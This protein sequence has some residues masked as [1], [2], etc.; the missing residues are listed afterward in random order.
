MGRLGD[1]MVFI[2]DD[3]RR[4]REALCDLL[5]SFDLPAVAFSSAAEYL[6]LKKKP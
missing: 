2:V 5:S 1:S 4:V 6:G 3:D